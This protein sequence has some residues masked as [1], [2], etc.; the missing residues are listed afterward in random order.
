MC[1]LLAYGHL[2]IL[3]LPQNLTIA[4]SNPVFWCMPQYSSSSILYS[5]LAIWAHI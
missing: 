1:A 5:V 4:L 2:S 3:P